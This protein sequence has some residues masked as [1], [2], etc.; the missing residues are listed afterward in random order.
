M[1]PFL[2]PALHVLETAPSL[3]SACSTFVQ[4][5]CAK[6]QERLRRI[7][8]CQN[9]HTCR[10]KASLEGKC[11]KTSAKAPC[12]RRSHPWFGLEKD[13]LPPRGPQ[14]RSL[15]QRL[16]C[17]PLS[18]WMCSIQVNIVQCPKRVMEVEVSTLSTFNFIG[19]DTYYITLYYIISLYWG[20]GGRCI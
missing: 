19:N 10:C 8:F 7:S 3:V 11:F 13:P 9:V 15:S 1:Y 2:C 14:S 5:K 20:Q 12:K 18:Q 4:Q 6:H 17:C 16:K